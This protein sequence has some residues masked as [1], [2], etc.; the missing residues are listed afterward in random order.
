MC[1]GIAKPRC[2]EASQHLSGT[3]TSGAHEFHIS[4]TNNLSAKFTLESCLQFR[5]TDYSSHPSLP[6]NLSI[7]CY[8]NLTLRHIVKKLTEEETLLQSSQSYSSY[9]CSVGASTDVSK[10]SGEQ[11]VNQ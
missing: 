5:V 2:G 7:E 3:I 11:S 8:L 9:H 1:D 10:P 6:E 4:C